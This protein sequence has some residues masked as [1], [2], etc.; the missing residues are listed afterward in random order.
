[1]S[2]EAADGDVSRCPFLVLRT[3]DLESSTEIAGRKG[4]SNLWGDCRLYRVVTVYI[5]A[6]VM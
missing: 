5:T 2:S 4:E 3:C 6:F 1:M